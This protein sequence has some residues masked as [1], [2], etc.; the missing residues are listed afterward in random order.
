MIKK[1]TINEI[2]LSNGI[3]IQQYVFYCT[4]SITTLGGVLEA[5]DTQGFAINVY[6][7]TSIDAHVFHLPHFIDDT[8]HIYYDAIQEEDDEYGG[9]SPS[10]HEHF[11]NWNKSKEE[12][13][14]D[15]AAK[16]K[17]PY[18]ADRAACLANQGDGA[19][20]L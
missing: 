14:E 10:E 6:S 5:I 2:Y 12:K 15:T 19:M 17:D 16:G 4:A 9:L 7:T 13:E 1:Q 3:E 20:L 11:I 8:M 18:H